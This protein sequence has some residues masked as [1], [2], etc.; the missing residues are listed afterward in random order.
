[1]KP[2]PSHGLHG[3]WSQVRQ[4]L[5]LATL[6]LGFGLLALPETHAQVTGAIFT[7]DT[8][9]TVNKN[10]YVAKTDVY[11]NGGPL[12][13]GAA[14]LPPGDY[15]CQVTTPDGDVL[16]QTQTAVIQVNA[17]GEFVMPYQLTS[18][19]YT[20]SS[21]FTTLGFDDTDNPGGEYKAWVTQNL[22]AAP[23]LGVPGTYPP[24]ESKTD[25]FKVKE[26]GGGDPGPLP[27]GEICVEKF[28]DA[29]VNGLFDLGEVLLAGWPIQIFD[30]ADV[31]V[32]T[33]VTTAPPD[34]QACLIDEPGT[35][36]AIEL[37]PLEDHWIHTTPAEVSGILLVD[38]QTTVVRFGNVCIGAGGG[39]TLGF[40][41][42]KNGQK[43]ILADDLAQLVAL[44][45]RKAD[46]SDF[47]P[48]S[49][50]T[51][52]TWLL[53]GNATNM[54]YMLSVQLSAMKLNVH[55]T[56][57]NGS[58][59]VYAPQLLDPAFPVTP[60]LNPLG[61]ISVNNL[62]AAANTELGLHG[63]VL[64]GSPF[65][66]YQEALKDALDDG[67]NNLNFVEPEPCPFTF[68]PF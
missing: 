23:L 5:M 57:V 35:Y 1:M 40:W 66:A 56:L 58:A 36:S 41:S 26:P 48:A 11:L 64:A 29:N 22:S 14:G 15:F 55:N 68:A 34:D 46:G 44:N 60:G 28:Y 65:R 63:L 12:H 27:E 17:L 47:D 13:P 39:K 4:L 6:S 10:I 52:R 59:L 25:N 9:G 20:A 33:L 24:N 31:L 54:A 18:I 50:T 61:F 49:K 43:L 45:L 30:S 51:F 53:G 32:A 3:F 7:T 19:L 42:N 16:G 2:A 38:A 62:M 37:D 8:L 21:G 67:N